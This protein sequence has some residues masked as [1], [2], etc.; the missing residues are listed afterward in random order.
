[1]STPTSWFPGQEELDSLYDAVLSGFDVGKNL[2]IVT[3]I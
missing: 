1:M 3:F 2:S